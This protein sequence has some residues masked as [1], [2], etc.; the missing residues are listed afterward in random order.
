MLDPKLLRNELESTAAQLA[1]RGYTLDVAR[2]SSLETQR[3]ALQIRTQELQNERN[4]RSK[5]IGR[6]KAS[7]QDIQ[8]LLNEIAGLGDQ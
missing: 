6:A 4:A 1:R 7:G 3:K 5:T 2:I 8:P